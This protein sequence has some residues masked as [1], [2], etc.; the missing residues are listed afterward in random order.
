MG[1]E[2]ERGV[3]RG[4]GRGNWYGVCKKSEQMKRV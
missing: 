4:V 2:K 1:C 3:R